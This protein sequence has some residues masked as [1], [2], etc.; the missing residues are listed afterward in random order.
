MI[1]VFLC[2]NYFT[3]SDNAQVHPCCCKW[4]YFILFVANAPLYMY[5]T[6][7]LSS[8]LSMDIQPHLGYCEQCCYEHWDAGSFLNY[9]FLQIYAQ[10]WDC[11]IDHMVAL[12]LVFLRNLHTILHSDC[13]NLH[14]HEQ[15]R[16]VLFSP[17]PLQHLLQVICSSHC[18]QDKVLTAARLKFE[19]SIRSLP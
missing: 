18:V 1:F 6:S 10:E 2:L 8:H 17:H 15:C 5:C 14:S 16:R 3:Q 9:S 19:D 11:W 7:S 13:V 12:F 4:C